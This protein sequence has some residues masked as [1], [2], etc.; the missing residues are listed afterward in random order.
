MSTD[1]EKSL[2]ECAID[3]QEE[4]RNIWRTDITASGEFL[5]L[6]RDA[7]EIAQEAVRLARAALW[8]AVIAFVISVASTIVNLSL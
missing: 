5:A 6:K 1:E 7:F 2:Q 4:D 3:L 8:I